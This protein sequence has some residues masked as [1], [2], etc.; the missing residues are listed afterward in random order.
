MHETS[1]SLF[2]WAYAVQTLPMKRSTE[3]YKAD[4]ENTRG[5]VQCRWDTEALLNESRHPAFLDRQ[6]TALH[7]APSPRSFLII[8]GL[9]TF[10]FA[11]SQ[12]AQL[13]SS[14]VDATQFMPLSARVVRLARGPVKLIVFFVSAYMHS[15]AIMHL[16][17]PF[18]P[19]VETEERKGKE[20]EGKKKDRYT[21]C[22]LALD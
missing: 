18:V 7:L 9:K 14:L 15:P 5:A 17:Y 11:L 3:W 19:L 20:E 1:A 12:H 16:L 22:A 8:D 10:S 21:A 4:I 13:S 6:D 2:V